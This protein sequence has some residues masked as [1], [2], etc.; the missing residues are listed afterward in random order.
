MTG[1]IS[2]IL[3]MGTHTIRKES[4]LVINHFKNGKLLSKMPEIIQ[5]NHFT[6]QNIAGRYK[7][8]PGLRVKRG[9]APKKFTT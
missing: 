4:Q 1:L 7:R 9:R 8:K 5:R 2:Q 3:D 6:V